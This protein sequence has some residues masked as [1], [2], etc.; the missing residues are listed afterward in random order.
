MRCRTTSTSRNGE[1]ALTT[2]ASQDDFTPVC[3]LR[4]DSRDL[5]VVYLPVGG[6]VAIELVDDLK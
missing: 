3:G 5:A 1:P 2:Q 6:S 4:N